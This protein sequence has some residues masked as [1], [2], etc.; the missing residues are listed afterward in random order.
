MLVKSGFHKFL[1]TVPTL[2]RHGYTLF[3]IACAVPGR[4]SVA[5]CDVDAYAMF[6]IQPSVHDVFRMKYDLT[7]F[8]YVVGIVGSRMICSCSMHLSESRK[9]L[10]RMFNQQ[11]HLASR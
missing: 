10:G 11:R 2:C 1:V 8:L 6:L 5:S 4:Q 9:S 7:G 3:L